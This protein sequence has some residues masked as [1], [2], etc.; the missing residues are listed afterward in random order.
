MA[1]RIPTPPVPH[2][3]LVPQPAPA[4]ADRR[5]QPLPTTLHVGSGKSFR[6]EWLNLDVSPMWRPDVVWDLNTP[7]PAARDGREC[8]TVAVPSERF[9]TVELGPRMFREVVAIDVLE[10]IREL[11]TAM[12]TILHLLEDGGV[13]RASVPYELSLGAW[14]DPTHVRAFNER[15]WVYYC[16]WAWYLGWSTHHFALRKLEFEPSA[17]GDE[18]IARGL[19]KDQI[20]R[21]PRAIDA[22]HVE[23]V[24][25]PMSAADRS[26]VQAM[27]TG[28]RRSPPDADPGHR[29]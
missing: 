1:I 19:G 20:V 14:C 17:F 26:A 23:L 5:R 7:L 11:T 15:S 2:D 8:G 4:P 21:T 29:P 27:R 16:E 12:T 9:G 18:L 10:H 6:A 28:A 25:T 13:L 24:R 3:L 22:M